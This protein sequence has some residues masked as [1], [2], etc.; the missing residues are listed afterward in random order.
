[1]TRRA[2][3]AS[4]SIASQAARERR[5]STNTIGTKSVNARVYEA[6]ICPAFL[7]LTSMPARSMEIGQMMNQLIAA[8]FLASTLFGIKSMCDRNRAKYLRGERVEGLIWTARHR[9]EEIALLLAFVASVV[10]YFY[11]AYL[12][13]AA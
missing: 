9:P 2:S 10:A 7:W 12:A 4:R 3:S 6:F 1:M 11:A 13:S 8:I 5:L